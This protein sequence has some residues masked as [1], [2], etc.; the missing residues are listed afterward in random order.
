MPTDNTCRQKVRVGLVGVG[1]CASSFTQGLSYYRDVGNLPAAGLMSP[2]IG[3]YGI[4]DVQ[5]VSAFDV[6][7]QKVGVGDRRLRALFR[8]LA[9]RSE[10]GP[11]KR[12]G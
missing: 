9:E 5:I 8:R 10:Q 6:S 4:G 12:L 1:N 2:E 11:G 7:A 3:G